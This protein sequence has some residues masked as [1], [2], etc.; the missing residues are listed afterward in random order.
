VPPSTI[1][2][3]QYWNTFSVGSNGSN[4]SASVGMYIS[5]HISIEAAAGED[6]ERDAI[7]AF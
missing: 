2:Q 6:V 3:Y 1:Q 7:A 5:N 4:F